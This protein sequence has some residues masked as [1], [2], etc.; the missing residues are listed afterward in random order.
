MTRSIVV[1]SVLAAGILVTGASAQERPN[2]SGAWSG[3]PPGPPARSGGPSASLGNGWGNSFTLIQEANLLIVERVLYRPRD[4]QPIL[5][6]R[7]ALDG[8]E[9][10]NTILMGRGMQVQRSTAAWDSDRLTITM[11]HDIP[12]FIFEDVA[13]DP[14]RLLE[15]FHSVVPPEGDL[16]PDGHQLS[17]AK[18]PVGGS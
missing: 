5:K 13:L 7:Y 8:S 2:I 9:S 1:L 18:V 12:E 17:N 6:F 10:Q 11:V 3:P 16:A 4:S 15:E 14:E